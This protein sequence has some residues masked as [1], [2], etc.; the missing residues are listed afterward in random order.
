M[1]MKETNKESPKVQEYYKKFLPKHDKKL[2][3]IHFN[4]VYNI[5]ERDSDKTVVAGSSRFVTAMD[6]YGS[7]EK[8]VLFSGDLFFPSYLSNHYN[9]S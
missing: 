2:E 1:A 8:L 3:I 5:E 6:Q 4:D 7:S 9:G